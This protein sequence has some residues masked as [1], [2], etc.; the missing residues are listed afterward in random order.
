[1][2]ILSLIG[3][4]GIGSVITLFLK[5]YFDNRKT[6]SKRAFEEKR[7]AYVNYLDIA[8]RSQTMSSEEGLWAR[9]AA[10]SRIEL[11][12]SLKVIKQLNLLISSKPP[13]P[14]EVLDELIQAMRDDLFP[15]A[16]QER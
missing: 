16:K 7:E 2:D 5:E 13:V 1:M 3:G 14:R 15:Q 8:S 4:L 11:C 6:I 9:T 12:G 10:M